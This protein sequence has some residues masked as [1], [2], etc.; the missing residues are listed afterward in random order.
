MCE[1]T[2]RVLSE[3]LHPPATRKRA[4][5]TAALKTSDDDDDDDVDIVR[6]KKVSMCNPYMHE[7]VFETPQVAAERPCPKKR[8]ETRDED[9]Q[10]RELSAAVRIDGTSLDAELD[11]DMANAHV[12]DTVVHKTY[13]GTFYDENLTNLPRGIAHWQNDPPDDVK[14]RIGSQLLKYLQSLSSLRNGVQLE[15]CTKAMRAL[16]ICSGLLRKE[17]RVLK[18]EIFYANLDLWE[19]QRQLDVSLLELCVKTDTSRHDMNI[20]AW[21]TAVM[22]GEIELH[23]MDGSAKIDGRTLAIPVNCTFLYTEAY[24]KVVSKADKVLF[25]EKRTI[26]DLVATPDLCKRFNC[27]MMTDGGNPGINC[28]ALLKKMHE[29][30]FGRP[31]IVIVFS[32]FGPYGFSIL[33][34]LVHVQKPGKDGGFIYG[35]S[36]LWGGLRPGQIQYLID[37]KRLAEH[38]AV[39]WTKQDRQR[40]AGFLVEGHP[41]VAESE[42]RLE[43]MLCSTEM[44]L[45]YDFESIASVPEYVEGVM[46]YNFGDTPVEGWDDPC[47]KMI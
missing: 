35:F 45:K 27:I 4:A 18:R 31:K 1:Y 10:M 7:H 19:E 36:F 8:D 25:F 47:L 32:D 14:R 2:N 17:E 12:S 44:Q 24:Y 16:R 30:K 22:F 33:S 37:N 29:G 46:A 21:P 13:K 40:Q 26:F 23:S 41:F 5:P 15:N 3:L 38:M 9:V 43:E 20:K 28:R 34:S 42:E 6:S 11:Y 39:A